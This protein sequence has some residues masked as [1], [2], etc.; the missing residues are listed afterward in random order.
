MIAIDDKEHTAEEV[1]SS[2]TSVVEMLEDDGGR[3][4]SLQTLLLEA[5]GEDA[6]APLLARLVRD[7]K[8]L[9]N[10][11]EAIDNLCEEAIFD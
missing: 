6:L 5:M 2:L 3:L 1:V 4:D 11:R 7:F 10:I 8:I 9:G